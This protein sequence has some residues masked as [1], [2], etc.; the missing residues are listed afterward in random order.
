MPHPSR[1]LPARSL[2]LW[3]IAVAGAGLTGFVTTTEP[4]ASATP[5]ASGAVSSDPAS[6]PRFALHEARLAAAQLDHAHRRV[7]ALEQ[8]AAATT[9]L[10]DCTAARTILAEAFGTA[11]EIADVAL[12]DLA[13]R[14]IAKRQAACA[15]MAGALAALP[16]IVSPGERDAVSIAVVSA[17]IAA[18]ELPQALEVAA[19]IDDPVTMSEAQR[20]IAVAQARRGRMSE[21]REI[22]GRIPDF[23]VRAMASADIAALHADIGNAQALNTA[24]LIARATPNARQRD[25]ALSYV[26]SIQAQ[27]GDVHSALGTSAAIK[28]GTSKAYALARIAA[29]RAGTADDPAVR[30]LLDRAF[31]TARRARPTVATAA[32]LCEIA[33]GYLVRGDVAQARSALDHA[34]T[35]ATSKRG[36]RYG[37]GAV[38]KI[39]RLR[40]RTGDIAGALAI[41]EGIPDGSSRAL[42]V[43]DILAVQ[44]EKDDVTGALRAA[45]ALTDVQLQVAALF[46]IVGV[47]MTSGDSAGARTSLQRV[48]ELA[49]ETQDLGFRSHSL[50]AVAAAQ[51]ALGDRSD[52]WPNFQDALAAAAA[53]PDAYARA[54]AYVNLSDPFTQRP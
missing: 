40:A 15:D 2:L 13:L 20:M 27:S 48:L 19:A 36:L 18:G 50:G 26:A 47:Q 41:A 7:Q 44:A 39:A 14:D 6:W 49:R 8:I 43:H 28:D 38:E 52:A 10:G 29:A 16:E 5:H 53:L 4:T 54:Y 12:R 21:A 22:A 23:L 35:V 51:V 34:Y 42:L 46:G 25:V 11:R 24:R 9:G 45:N 17:Q 32:V 1:A 31:S 30:E 37:A 33:Q 3:T